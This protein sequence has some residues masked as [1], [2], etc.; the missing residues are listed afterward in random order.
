MPEPSAAKNNQF[1]IGFYNLENLFD[2]VNDPKKLDDDFTP[3]SERKWDDRKFRKKVKKIG[4]VISNL[5]YKDIGHSPVLIG[6]AEVENAVA[7]DGLVQ[8]KFLKD[9]NYEYVHFDS[10]D[11]RGIDTAL[12]YRREYFTVISKKAHTLYLTNEHGERDFTRDVLHVFGNLK[13]QAVHLLINHW[14]SRRSGTEETSNKRVTAALKNREILE[15]IYAEDPEARIIVMGDF[16]DD[17]FSESVQTL[18]AKELFNPM[19]VLLSNTEGSLNY[20]MTWHLF[21]QIIMS[22]NFLRGYDNSFKFK[23]AKIHN[24]EALQEFKGKYKGQ[25][26]RTYVGKKYLGGYSDHF[27]VYA[28]FSID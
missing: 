9:K 26:F 11:E 18:I 22:H 10:P 27:P 12:L 20:K 1:T 2:T 16:N 19:E 24:M 5:G 17:P 14:P 7:L 21:D 25:P 13:D 28:I 6:L 15:G 8:S 23:E 3:T 4:R